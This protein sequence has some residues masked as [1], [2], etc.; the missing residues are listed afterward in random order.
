MK[1]TMVICHDI[2]A[3]NTFIQFWIRLNW[4]FLFLLLVLN[5]HALLVASLNLIVTLLRGKVSELKLI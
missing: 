4:N 1:N 3:R 5:K 2:I